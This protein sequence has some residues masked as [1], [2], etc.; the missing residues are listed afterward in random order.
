MA[1]LTPAQR[2]LRARI[3]AHESWANTDD[4][5]AR[6]KP[7]RDKWFQRFLDE[8]DPD[9]QLPEVERIRRAESKMRAYMLRLAERSAEARRE[10]ADA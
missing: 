10:R 8:V 1:D 7:A 6:T 2:S 3:A 5:A 4:R 9:R